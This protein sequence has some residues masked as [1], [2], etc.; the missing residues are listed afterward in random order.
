MPC[1]E[2][3]IPR[4]RRP[5]QDSAANSYPLGGGA[6]K[7][8]APSCGTGPANS[9][10]SILLLAGIYFRVDTGLNLLQGFKTKLGLCPVTI[11]PAIGIKLHRFLI[12]FDS[13][14]LNNEL[15]LVA[16]FLG[17][18]RPDQRSAQQIP[19]LGIF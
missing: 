8:P 9:N 12:S 13:S 6:K 15:Q 19:N 2:Y 4:Q 3:K 18:H 14:R 5:V 7:R 17:F 11:G 1:N 10:L 16:V